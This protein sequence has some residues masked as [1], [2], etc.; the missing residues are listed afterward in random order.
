MSLLLRV[1][2]LI[3]ILGSVPL[4]VEAIDQQDNTSDT[5]NDA[6]GIIQNHESSHNND[7]DNKSNMTTANTI[8]DGM[9]SDAPAVPTTTDGQPTVS[10]LANNGI[11]DLRDSNNTNNTNNTHGKGEVTVGDSVMKPSHQ[12]R[13]H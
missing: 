10:Q 9:A 3:A 12:S 8:L 7:N 5:P 4:R 1:T 11:Q 13:R 6:V 2:V